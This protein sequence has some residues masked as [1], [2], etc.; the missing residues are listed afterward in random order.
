MVEIVQQDAPMLFGW[1]EEYAGAYHQWL[2]NGKPSNIIRDQLQYLRINASMRAERA[3]QWNKPELWPLI[4]IL[5]GCILLL[6]PAALALRARR[7]AKALEQ[8]GR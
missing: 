1:S 5:F 8:P 3:A 7:E 6:L 4:L 2:A